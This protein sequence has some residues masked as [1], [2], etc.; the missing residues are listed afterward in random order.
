M[1]S[2]IKIVVSLL[3][4]MFSFI[5]CSDDDDAI[6][7]E[8]APSIEEKKNGDLILADPENWVNEEKD[9]RR[10][11]AAGLFRHIDFETR[12]MILCS[13]QIRN[14]SLFLLN[15]QGD[16]IQGADG[17]WHFPWIGYPIQQNEKELTLYHFN[18]KEKDTYRPKSR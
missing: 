12:N 3:L 14:D 6:D 13:Y 4:A 16:M 10:F 5:G 9:A 8:L 18:G 2:K 7:L 1:N 11:T 15:T 17:K